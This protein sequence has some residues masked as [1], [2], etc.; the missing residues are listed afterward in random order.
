[1][2]GLGALPT[3]KGMQTYGQG[4]GPS[5]F[6]FLEPS[7]ICSLALLQSHKA[8]HALR[9]RSGWLRSRGPAGACVLAHGTC[10]ASPFQAAKLRL[11]PPGF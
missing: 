10:S 5:F 1:M 9:T 2:R 7:S 4:A 3:S 6:P 8:G 11:S